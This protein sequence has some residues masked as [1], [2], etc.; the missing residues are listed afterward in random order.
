MMFTKDFSLKDINASECLIYTKHC[1]VCNRYAAGTGL[2]EKKAYCR[3][4]LSDG[5]P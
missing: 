5:N 4:K 3:Q 2:M 1:T